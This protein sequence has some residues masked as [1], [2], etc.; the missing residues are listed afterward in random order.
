MQ[1]LITI[2]T[3]AFIVFTTL[4]A[5]PAAALQD[6]EREELRRQIRD[7]KSWQLAR[8]LGLTDEQA[9]E[10]VPL[11][12]SFD[13]DRDALRRERRR[14]ES[15]LEGLV[16]DVSG[17]KEQMRGVM[18][19]MRDVDQRLADRERRFRSKAYRILNLEQQ[20]RYELFEKRFNAR[21]RDLIKDVRREQREEAESKRK[22]REDNDDNDRRRSKR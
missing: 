18:L 15:E 10:F 13:R 16:G 19:R 5:A 12:E 9:R 8:E 17:N 14:L 2:A 6:Q 3:L 7:V 21:L 20:A 11:L 1:K 22:S 4:G